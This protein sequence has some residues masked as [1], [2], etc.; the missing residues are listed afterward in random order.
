[1]H[2]ES[3]FLLVHISAFS[4]SDMLGLS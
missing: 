4:K 2:E 1:V 3:R